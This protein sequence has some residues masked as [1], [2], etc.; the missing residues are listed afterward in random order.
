MSMTCFSYGFPTRNALWPRGNSRIW[1]RCTNAEPGSYGHECVEPAGFIASNADGG[2]ACFCSACKAHGSEA[3]RYA[4]WQALPVMG[5][6]ESAAEA[7]ARAPT[8]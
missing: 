7:I 2:Q 6:G 3:R 8:S 5:Q 4:H 1:P